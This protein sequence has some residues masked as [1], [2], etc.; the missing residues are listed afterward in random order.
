MSLFPDRRLIPRREAS[1]SSGFGS[2]VAVGIAVKLGSGVCVG[3]SVD[4]G[5]GDGEA[6]G[7]A[8]GEGVA[9][10]NCVVSC[11]DE[12]PTITITTTMKLKWTG[13][14]RDATAIMG[15]SISLESNSN[16][17]PQRASERY[18][19]TAASSDFI[20]E[21]RLQNAGVELFASGM[22]RL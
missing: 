12:H 22:E 18:R 11:G 17:L 13:L 3:V 9:E 14:T 15:T 19:V 6:C 2:G 7:V 16:G 1:L 10:A 4:E 8:E 20:V 5:A 21:A